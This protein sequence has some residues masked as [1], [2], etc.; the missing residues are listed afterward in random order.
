M[1]GLADRFS[2]V[3]SPLGEDERGAASAM[4]LQRLPADVLRVVLQALGDP[5]ALCHL[6]RCSS[7]CADAANDAAVWRALFV[8][9]Y[10]AVEAPCD[11]LMTT[12]DWRAR[13]AL[14]RRDS[15]ASLCA[16]TLSCVVERVPLI[17]CSRAVAQSPVVVSS[18]QDRS[19][20][21]EAHFRAAVDR[22]EAAFESGEIPVDDAAEC[23]DDADGFPGGIRR[24]ALV[25]ALRRHETSV[26]AIARLALNEAIGPIA[27][28]CSADRPMAKAWTI[29]LK[30]ASFSQLRDCRGFRA[31]DDVAYVDASLAKLLEMPA[32]PL[33]KALE[34]GTVNEVRGLYLFEEQCVSRDRH[35]T[36]P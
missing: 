36:N 32:H 9:R 7:W 21:T 26:A 15:L 30:I 4:V 27:Q 16:L 11:P 10:G 25:A 8:R 24:L 18:Q 3:A 14:R 28:R 34:R 35:L 33:W 31:R 6:A 29:R 20:I 1:L 13:F 5:C 19:F 22:L 2:S 23:F 17:A 12:S